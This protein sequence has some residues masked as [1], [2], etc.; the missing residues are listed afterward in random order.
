M[1]ALFGS[2]LC[3]S[4]VLLFLVQPM[5]AKMLL[6]VLGGAPAVWTTCVVFYQV[7]LLLGYVYAH[8]TVGWLG[9]R[10][11]AVLHLALLAVPWFFLPIGFPEG[12]TPPIG[13]RPTVPL[14]LLLVGT[15]G[16][17]FFAVASHAPL[18]QNWFSGTTHVDGRDPYFLY[19]PSN[20]GSLLAL[21]SYPVVIE[22][23]IGLQIQSR[24]WAVG[25]AV[26][27]VLVLACACALWRRPAP[28]L[29]RLEPSPVA[30][31]DDSDHD[32]GSQ[33]PAARRRLRWIVLAAAPSSL[34]LSVTTYTATDIAA[35]PLLWVLP[36][37][38][39]LG[40]F[41]LAFARRPAVP[42]RAMITLLPVAVLPP[43]VSLLANT[44]G[45]VWLFI[46]L[47]LVALF[48]AAMVCHG[49]LAR[50]R[51]GAR[52]LTEFY[53][54]MAVGGSLGGL[55]NVLLAPLI[56][57]GA[58][59]YPLGLVAVCLL[60]PSVYGSA[61]PARARRLD[62]AL[63][64]LAALLAAG[65]AWA[66]TRANLPIGSIS[67]AAIVF[68][69]PLLV[70]AGFWPRSLRF[71]LGIAGLLVVSLAGMR[72]SDRLLFV[73]RDFFGTRRV[74]LEHDGRYRQ[75][76]NGTTIH[77]MQAVD[78]TRRREP[79]AYYT[80]TGPAGDVFAV[81]VADDHPRRVAVI[82]LGVGAL[83]CYGRPGEQ[84]T[85]YEIDPIVTRL[86][87]DRKYFSFLSEC[88]PRHKLELGD[89]RRSL[90]RAPD[91]RYDLIIMDA[92]SSDAIP[93]HLITREAV[94][95][96]V[97]K[98]APGGLLAFHISNRH[99]DLEP[100][101]AGVAEEAGLAGV[102]RHD[103]TLTDTDWERGKLPSHWVV[104]AHTRDALE[105]FTDVG[106]KELSGG[107]RT[108]P[109][110]DDFSNIVGALKWR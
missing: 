33:P 14:L 31:T 60:R 7:T 40:S 6:P 105:A 27:S 107:N 18:L 16:L 26:L 61:A 50:S 69:L 88:L 49:E 56:F 22:P 97:R 93:V 20:L 3:V 82:G 91:H 38:I 17:P 47:H 11:Q 55:F 46:P 108:R 43:V 29:R 4:A 85:F 72:F 101:L 109:W 83:A 12:W 74:V 59:E 54:W 24:A 96:Y 5:V 103:N 21:V 104:L 9:A 1:L 99:L 35:V 62:V 66:A 45:A 75:L 37:A 32:G 41:V 51:P 2:T 48:V 102:T 73:G 42:H 110:T 94:R 28:A 84:W 67:H 77:G 106:W 23:L 65:L 80:R 10:R 95:L 71:G 98:L 13:D 81:L 90:V 86:A 19:G 25:Y 30:L 76:I 39:Y 52:Y 64:M 8:A 79:L 68:G 34:M 15:V 57:D 36:L 100:V 44:S 92:F 53:L 78:I 70:C 58:T 87:N 63:P 89:A